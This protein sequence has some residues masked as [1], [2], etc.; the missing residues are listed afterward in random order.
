MVTKPLRK[1]SK[2]SAISSSPKVTDVRGI[3]ITDCALLGRRG[4]LSN[5]FERRESG[6]MGDGPLK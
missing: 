5:H 2:A 1:L 3:S 6:D 4:Q